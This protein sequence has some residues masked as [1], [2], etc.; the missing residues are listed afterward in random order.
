MALKFLKIHGDCSI[1]L[2]TIFLKRYLDKLKDIRE[3]TRTPD[4]EIG[5]VN[6]NPLTLLWN[7]Y[8]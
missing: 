7:T 4:I 6:K 8:E 5:I 3:P 2:V 1:Y